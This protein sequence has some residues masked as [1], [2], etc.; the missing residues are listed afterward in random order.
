MYVCIYFYAC[1][2]KRDIASKEQAANNNL[3]NKQLPETIKSSSKTKPLTQTRQE[4][5]QQIC[6]GGK[7]LKN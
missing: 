4:G 5:L 2:F 6:C 7:K 3:T 1:Q